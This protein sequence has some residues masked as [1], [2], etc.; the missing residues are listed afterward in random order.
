MYSLSL[1]SAGADR[2]RKAGIAEKAAIVE[3]I[4]MVLG[5]AEIVEITKIVGIIETGTV[6]M[7]AEVRHV[8]LSVTDRVDRLVVAIVTEEENARDLLHLVLIDRIV[9][10]VVLHLRR[11]CK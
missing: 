2:N 4:E 10:N 5:M 1:L 11:S 6:E 8:V 7:E 3:I 9:F